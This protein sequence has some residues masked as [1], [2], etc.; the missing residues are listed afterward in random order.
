MYEL[1]W[2]TDWCI[3]M[4]QATYN[5]LENNNKD[6]CSGININLSQSKKKST[7]WYVYRPYISSV[8]MPT[9]FGL[10]N[11]YN[12]S[13]SHVCNIHKDT[14]CYSLMQDIYLD[15]SRVPPIQASVSRYFQVAVPFIH[16]RATTEAVGHAT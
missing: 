10:A 8:G 5:I 6:E 15:A 9:V 13:M 16:T 4:I 2:T 7:Y 14:Q 1:S 12:C 11:T 3:I